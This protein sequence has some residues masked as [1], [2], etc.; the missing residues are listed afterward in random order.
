MKP[1]DVKKKA[2]SARN[3]ARRRLRGSLKGTKAMEIFKTERQRERERGIHNLRGKYKHLDLMKGLVEARKEE[4]QPDSKTP[5]AISDRSLKMLD[6]S[7]A[8]LKKGFAS[9]PITIPKTRPQ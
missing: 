8:N 5:Y 2:K 9:P 6:K 3:R 7:V 1:I 4:R